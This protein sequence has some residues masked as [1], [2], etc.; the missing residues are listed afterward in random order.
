MKQQ[1]FF[2]AL[3]VLLTASLLFGITSCGPKTCPEDPSKCPL[4]EA[5]V[6]TEFI[7]TNRMLTNNLTG[8]DYIIEGDIEVSADF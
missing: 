8:V 5:E 6:I 1:I 3:S 2:P 7:N 4:N